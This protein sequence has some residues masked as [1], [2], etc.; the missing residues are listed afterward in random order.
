MT[1]KI[2]DRV[3]RLLSRRAHDVGHAA[4]EF[5]HSVHDIERAAAS[6]MHREK[7]DKAHPA[8]VNDKPAN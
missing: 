3:G 5:G 4:M 7:A 8:I 1:N 6:R 2:F